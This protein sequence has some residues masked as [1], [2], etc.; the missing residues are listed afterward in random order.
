MRNLKT[1]LVIDT[2]LKLV[3]IIALIVAVETKQQYSYFTFLRWLV[4]ATF[5]YFAYKA[6]DKKQIGFLIYF[7]IVAVLFNPV[8]KFWFQKETWHL[9][10][11]IVIVITFIKTIYDLIILFKNINNNK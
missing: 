3:V 7:G 11:Y 5:I 2:L 6:Y 10:D 1:V 9:I 4:M 8:H